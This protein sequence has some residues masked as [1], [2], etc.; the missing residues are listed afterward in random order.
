MKLETF[1][2]DTK[3]V[4]VEGNGF[5]V[6]AYRWANCEG[7]SVLLHGDGRDLPIRASFSLRWEELDAL[8]VA[9]AAARAA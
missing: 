4:F 9:L 1:T 8:M 6:S 3:E 5:N 7:V 2:T